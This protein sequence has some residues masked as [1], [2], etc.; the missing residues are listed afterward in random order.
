MENKHY[1]QDFKD[2]DGLFRKLFEE[3][4][5]VDCGLIPKYNITN[6]K[7]STNTKIAIWKEINGNYICPKCNR[8]RKLKKIKGLIINKI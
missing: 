4:A 2:K 8:I 6:T 5:C 1:I 3:Y 7:N